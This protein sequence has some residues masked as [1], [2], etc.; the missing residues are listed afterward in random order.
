M[1][2]SKLY[3]GQKLKQIILIIILNIIITCPLFSKNNDLFKSI[4]DS[5]D[6]LAVKVDS[7]AIQVLSRT[8]TPSA[9]VAVVKNGIIVYL[10]A[11]GNA[12]LN[13]DVA[14]KTDMRYAIGSISKQFTAASILI[15]EQEGKL[16]LDDPVSK[17]MPDLTDADEVTIRELLSHTSGYQDF[18]PQDYAPP[19][20]LK[21]MPP[22]EILNRWAKKPLDFE[23]G[24]KWQYSNTNFV[25]AAQIVEKITNQPFFDFLKDNILYPLGL[26]SA[27]NFD[28]GK[29]TGEDP[30]GYMQYGLGPLRP[31]PEEGE[32]WMAGAGELAMTPHDLAKWDISMIKQS[33]LNPES[34][35]ELET[36]VLLK[37]GVGTR[38]GLGVQVGMMNNHRML[39]HGGEVSGFT[40]YNAVFPDDSAAVVVLTNQDASPAAGA[41][42][43]KIFSILFNSQ[44]SQTK[45]RTEQAR[46]IFTGLQNGTI[47]RSLFTSDANAYF[48]DQALKDFQSSLDTLGEP[49]EFVQ[50]AQRERGGMLLR[51]FRVE[52]KDRNLRIWTY[53]MPDGKLEQYQVAP[54]P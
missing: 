27:V 9:S 30:T 48:S 52:F 19:M 25:I 50:T 7:A 6:S 53:Q 26:S 46:E 49:D 11:Y 40:A 39:S 5:H 22:R 33:L 44:D 31:A 41:I 34:Y 54:Q 43:R 10:Q 1:K 8:G 4:E 35:K 2:I 36:E 18:W 38:Y 32:G 20:M 51:L 45:I 29:L 15:L 23:P 3:S 37:N 28:E 12:K 21:P 24:T 16:S 17:W 42:A 47:D 13:P 14:A